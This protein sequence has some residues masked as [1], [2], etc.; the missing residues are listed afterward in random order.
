MNEAPAPAAPLV[1][2]PSGEAVRASEVRRILIAPAVAPPRLEGQRFRVILE[3]V[4]G[5]RR[6]LATGLSREDAQDLVRRCVRALP[7]APDRT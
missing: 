5:E 7:E 2:L 3:T 4:D 6:P 1:L